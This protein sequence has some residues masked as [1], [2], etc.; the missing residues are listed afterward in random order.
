MHLLV[1]GEVIIYIDPTHLVHQRDLEIVLL[2]DKA[3]VYYMTRVILCLFVFQKKEAD[4]LFT[5]SPNKPQICTS[6]HIPKLPVCCEHP[7]T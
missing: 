2:V 4:N 7:D 1:Q 3:A 6:L 5:H